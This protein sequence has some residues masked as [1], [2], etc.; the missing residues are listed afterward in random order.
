MALSFQLIPLALILA[1][2]SLA[3]LCGALLLRVFWKVDF[4]GLVYS[5]GE[6]YG[7]MLHDAFG[8]LPA[9]SFVMGGHKRNRFGKTVS[10]WHCDW[11]RVST[12]IIESEMAWFG[13]PNA[14][15]N[16][17]QI[18]QYII[19]ADLGS[20]GQMVVAQLGATSKGRAQRMRDKL[21]QEFIELRPA[22]MKHLSQSLKR[23]PAPPAPRPHVV[24]GV[25]SVAV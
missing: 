11:M 17:G 12:F 8:D 20:E 15:L 25:A 4:K 23:P 24:S 5:E 9:G 16:E 22:A 7:G 6:V 14:K 19:I 2:V 18:D 21:Q 13:Y 3:I 10:S 1:P